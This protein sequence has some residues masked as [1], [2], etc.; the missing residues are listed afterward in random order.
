MK[1]KIILFLKDEISFSCSYN[2]NSCPNK[3]NGKPRR[4]S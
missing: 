2:F 1:S 4:K 3:N